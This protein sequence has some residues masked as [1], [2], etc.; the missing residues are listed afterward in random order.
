MEMSSE[1]DGDCVTR[2]KGTFIRDVVEVKA[3]EFSNGLDM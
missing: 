3:T 2:E 1:T